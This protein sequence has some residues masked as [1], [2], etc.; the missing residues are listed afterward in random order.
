MGQS[1]WVW[2]WDPSILI[3][4]AIWTAGYI[5]ITGP[6]LRRKGWTPAINPLRQISFH[7]GTLVAFLALVSPLDHLSDEFLLSAH[8]L[9]HLLLIMVAPPLWL[10]GFQATWLDPL[11]QKGWFSSLVKASTRPV[12]AFFIYTGVFLIWHVPTFYTA[13]LDNE[14]I[15]AFEHLSFMASAL[16]GWWPILGFLPKTA[17]RPTYPGQMAYCFLL[18]IPTTMLAAL[19]SFSSGPIYPFYE[20][21]P[22]VIGA[23]L[24]SA[25]VGGSRLWGISVLEDQQISG[26]MMWVP[27]NM[28]YF[29]AFMVVLSH[30]FNEND[31]KERE[32]YL[33]ED[34]AR[35]EDSVPQNEI[36]EN[37]PADMSSR[38]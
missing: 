24:A 30:W 5:Y 13:A 29:L 26:L 23:H 3:G 31:R 34:Q 32:K 20:D 37:E 38:K 17:P 1:I 36:F 22:T 10:I 6:L 12:P 28:T 2:A 8:M 11:I 35:A 15:H 33:Q 21:A 25:Q 19:I 18:M 4:L 16:V 14:V 27:A 7:L 9:Q